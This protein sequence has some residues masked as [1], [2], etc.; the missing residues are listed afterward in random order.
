MLVTFAAK[1]GP[2]ATCAGL[3]LVAD[4][5]FIGCTLV[6]VVD[7]VPCGVLADDLQQG[8][9][10]G[11]FAKTIPLDTQPQTALAKGVVRVD[12]E[13]GNQDRGREL[14]EWFDEV[15][16]Q[17]VGLTHSQNH[18]GRG[19]RRAQA[20]ASRFRVINDQEV[21]AH[22]QILPNLKGGRHRQRLILL[23]SLVDKG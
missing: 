18:Q 17:A 8:I 5:L 6:G 3:V 7:P 4:W 1:V 22:E 23:S 19:S 10:V 13:H 15:H 11:A 20:G 9:G 2:P 14:L 12:G 16:A 21:D